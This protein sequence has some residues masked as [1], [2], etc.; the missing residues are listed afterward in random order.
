MALFLKRAPE[1]IKR[2]PLLFKGGSIH[3]KHG[4]FHFSSITATQST[5][6]DATSPERVMEER[7]ENPHLTVNQNAVTVFA[8]SGLLLTTAMSI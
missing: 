1:C 7:R 4:D 6:S 2:R 8:E 5:K 3:W